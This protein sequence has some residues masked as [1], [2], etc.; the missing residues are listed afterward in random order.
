LYPNA[1]GAE[2]PLLA[3][4]QCLRRCIVQI[5]QVIIGETQNQLPQ[6]VHGARALAP[7]NTP[8]IPPIDLLWVEALPPEVKHAHILAIQIINV[9]ANFWQ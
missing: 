1:T 5:H 3:T 8:G 6:R 4:K 9:V 2:R 7:P